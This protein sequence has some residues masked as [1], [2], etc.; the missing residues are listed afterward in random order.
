[1]SRTNPKIL[2]EFGQWLRT[3]LEEK[4]LK[5]GEAARRCGISRVH[6]AR[7]LSGDTGFSHQTVEAIAKGL[8]L[9]M[10]ETLRRAGFAP[11]ESD[12]TVP[13]EFLKFKDLP[14]EAQEIIRRHIEAL[15]EIYSQ[16]GIRPKLD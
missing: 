11:A 14:P 2:V 9:N 6:L 4:H 15:A 13:I 10:N 3:Q 8:N 12:A 1:M 16:S 7:M 5:Q